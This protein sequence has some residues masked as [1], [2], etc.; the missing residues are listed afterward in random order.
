METKK[1]VILVVGRKVGMAQIH[2]AAGNYV[3]TT[4]IEIAP[5][6]VVLVRTPGKDGYAAI[7]IA[8]EK[9]KTHRLS[10]A[11][12]GHLTKQGCG[13]HRHLR[14]LRI[15][16][17][18]DYVSGEILN[19]SS[20]KVGDLVDVSGTT[21]GRGFQGVVK[22]Y[23]FE[24]GPKS[25][26][27]MFH[28]RGGSYGQREEPGRVYPGRKMPGHMGVRKRTTQNLE[29]LHVRPES[30]LLFVRGSI[31]GH[32]DGLIAVRTAKKG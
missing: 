16:D 17:S 6:P 13:P 8:A 18:N 9:T 10:K 27:S 3:A 11:E 25:H 14:E 26:G 19:V 7:Q 1:R 28:R 30:N 20:F 4:A 31:A 5:C 32:N 15:A 29:V 22:R 2:D 24:G 12:A 21:K 23:G